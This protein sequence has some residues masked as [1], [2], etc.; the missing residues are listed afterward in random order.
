MKKLMIA[1]C[2]VVFAA[3]SQ[4]ALINWQ[5]M[6]DVLGVTLTGL[7]GNGPY[8]AGGELAKDV[9]S[10]SY[11]MTI[12]TADGLTVLDDTI[13]GTV[14]FAVFGAGFDVYGIETKAAISAGTDYQYKIVMNGTQSDLQ[15]LGEHGDWDYSAATVS[16]TLTGTF[17]GATGSSTIDSAVPAT[18]TISGAEAIPEPTSGLLLLL[19]VAGLALRRRRA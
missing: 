8:A 5:S 16:A 15:A 6:D 1:A 11:A 12:Y 3:A 10:L 13:N 18:W 7:N 19:G 9:S 17:E 4:A 2:A 14:D